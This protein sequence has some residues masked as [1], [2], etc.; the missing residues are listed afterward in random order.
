MGCDHWAVA[1]IPASW[2][3]REEKS[4]QYFSGN[5][6]FLDLRSS[7]ANGAELC[8]AV[9]FFHRVILGKAIASKDLYCII[10]D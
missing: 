3:L 9:V 1:A 6:H 7:L 10:G 2:F 8:I 4:L 5:H